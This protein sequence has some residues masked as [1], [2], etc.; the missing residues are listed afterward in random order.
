MR[1]GSVLLVPVL[2]GT[3]VMAD[4]FNIMTFCNPFN[5]CY[6]YGHQVGA[7]TFIPM[8]ANEGCRDPPTSNALNNVSNSPLPLTLAGC[9]L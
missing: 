7:N 9:T 6:S 3:G 8:D 5:R 4:Y 2:A 1:L